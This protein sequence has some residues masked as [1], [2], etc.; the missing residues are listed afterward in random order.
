MIE[1]YAIKRNKS[2]QYACKKK[3]FKFEIISQ[4][5]YVSNSISPIYFLNKYANA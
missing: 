5:K 4:T 3:V 1:Y 2:L